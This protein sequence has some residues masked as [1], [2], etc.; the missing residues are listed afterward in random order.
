MES[1]LKVLK[2]LRKQRKMTQAELAQKMN[3]ASNTI[4]TWEQG[5]REPSCADLKKL[6]DIF[7]V[8]IDFLLSRSNVVQCP[9]L[10]KEQEKLLNDFKDLSKS[11]QQI[12]L[13][14]IGAFLTQQ[15][16]KVFGNV[17]NN[18]NSGSGIF[19]VNQGDNY[20]FGA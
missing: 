13:T 15:A 19:M 18:N 20:N 5:N 8:S 10:T 14:T 11:N 2:E 12:I 4:S 1:S 9:S 16:A 3:V 6:A 17:I 7:N